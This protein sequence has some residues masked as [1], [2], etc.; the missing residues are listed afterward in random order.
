MPRVGD[1]WFV[2]SLRGHLLIAGGGLF[3]PNFRRTVVLIGEHNEEGSLGVVLNRPA[4][5]RID[6]AVPPLASIVAPDDH[7]FF[8]GPVQPQSP[9][10]LA[11]FEHPDFADLLVFGSVGFLTGEALPESREGIVRAR[12]FAG[13]AGWGPGQ[14]EAEMDQDSW[15]L[16][17][18]RDEDVFTPD[19][20]ELWSAVL[21]RKGRE[22]RLLASMPFDPS[23]N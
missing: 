7:L 6:E 16:E 3:D 13:Y 8:G 19:P 2:E 14:L 18:A 15:I 21:R 5:F 9:V 12:V 23:I 17:P 20:E 1:D 11:E 22:Y 10:V 4:P